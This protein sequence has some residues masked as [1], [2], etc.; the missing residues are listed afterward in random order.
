M[1]HRR[2]EVRDYE[3]RPWRKKRGYHVSSERMIRELQLSSVD[4]KRFIYFL[5]L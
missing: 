5:E 1:V 4:I 3:Q 2:Y